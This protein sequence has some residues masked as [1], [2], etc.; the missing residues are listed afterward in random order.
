M[1]LDKKFVAVKHANSIIYI[2]NNFLDSIHKFSMAERRVLWYFLRTYK[3]NDLSS[4]SVDVVIKHNEYASLFNIHTQ[5]AGFEI[6]AACK[7]LTNN[8]WYIPRPEWKGNILDCLENKILSKEEMTN[9]EAFESGNIVDRCKFGVRNNESEVYFTNGFLELILP[10]KNDIFTQ[11][12]LLQAKQ[13]TNASHIALYEEFRRWVKAGSYIVTPTKLINKLQLPHTY[14]AY[15]QMRR[16]FLTPAISAI[17]GKTDLD[18]ELKEER[19]NPD[20]KLS[21]VV[22]LIFKINKKAEF[23]TELL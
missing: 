19:L 21:K 17:N 15:S 5:Q 6:A 12:R 23:N 10:I 11:Y 8:S 13:I 4:I 2:S 14:S 1:V 20:N 18:I 7:S 22:T 16:G 3:F 9:L